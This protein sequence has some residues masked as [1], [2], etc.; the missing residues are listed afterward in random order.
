[1]NN[2]ITKSLLK[3]IFESLLSTHVDIE[4]GFV[5]QVGPDPELAEIA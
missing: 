2:T 5:K 4:D 3:P 1:M